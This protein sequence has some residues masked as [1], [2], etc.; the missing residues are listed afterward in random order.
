MEEKIIECVEINGKMVEVPRAK[1]LFEREKAYNKFL[2]DEVIKHF[3][4]TM[5]FEMPNG[6]KEEEYVNKMENNYLDYSKQ[7]DEY[8]EKLKEAANKNKKTVKEEVTEWFQ[9]KFSKKDEEEVENN[10]EKEE[11]KPKKNIIKTIL[12]MPVVAVKGIKKFFT[13]NKEKEEKQENKEETNEKDF[14]EKVKEANEELA[15]KVKEEFEKEKDEETKITIEKL[16]QEINE[17]KS[18][19]K[20]QVEKINQLTLENKK[21]TEKVKDLQKEK[22]EEIWKEFLEKEEIKE[23]EKLTKKQQE[24]ERKEIIQNAL[25]QTSFTRGRISYNKELLENEKFVLNVTDKTRISNYFSDTLPYKIEKLEDGTIKATEE[26]IKS[27]L[28]SKVIREEK[29]VTLSEEECTYLFEMEKAN[30]EIDEY[31]LRKYFGNEKCKLKVDKSKGFV[32]KNVK[33][34]FNNKLLEKSYTYT[35]ER[36][37]EL[38]DGALRHISDNIRLS[39]TH[40]ELVDERIKKLMK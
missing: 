4:L 9:N 1:K 34:D 3:P 10:E 36:Y 38:V 18:L 39:E 5:S 17:L 15:K 21:L 11:D 26:G 24:E 30:L 19:I 29:T 27:Y 33:T 13:K 35:K 32:S 25:N 22:R 31:S 7:V 23:K 6:A 37:N 16:Q 40:P 14:E 2:R 20:P 12:L 28:Y 8:V